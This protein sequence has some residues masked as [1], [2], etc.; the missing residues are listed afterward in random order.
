MAAK[1]RSTVVGVFEDRHQADRAIAELKRA[2]FREDQIGVIT[3]RDET[4]ATAD[5]VDTDDTHADSGALTGAL[6]GAGLGALAGLGILAGVIPVIGPAIAGGTLGVILSNA[7]VGAGVAGL[8]G[9]LI[10]AGIPEEEASY[11]EGE[12]SAGRTLVTVQANGRASEATTILR[13][14]GAYDMSSR[15][16]ATSTTSRA[17]DTTI[18][19][20]AAGGQTIE[21]RE[22]RLQTRKQPVEAGEVRVRKD[23]VTEHKTVDVPVQREEVVIER[24]APAAGRP[25]AGGEI[26]AGEELRIPVK[27]EQV[28]VDKQAVVKE[29]VS[30]GKRTVQDTQRVSGDVR[31]EQVRVEKKGDVDVCDTPDEG[32][33]S[34]T[35]G[36]SKRT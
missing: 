33:R 2:G 13:R 14:H 29:E 30:V 26:R 24:H 36:G 3:R 18:E 9:A 4:L 21:V 11:Y 17:A 23:V 22:E 8:A 7:A 35:R 31:K 5:D 28:R 27:E 12:L 32:T 16:A 19:M 1:T 6:A 20:P 25:A 34:T 15:A 10:G